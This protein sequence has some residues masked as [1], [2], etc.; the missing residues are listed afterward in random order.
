M[1]LSRAVDCRGLNDLERRQPG[2]AQ[3]LKLADMGEAAGLADIARIR[4][5]GRSATVI[6][7]LTGQIEPLAIEASPRAF[8]FAGP[9]VVMAPEIGQTPR[10]EPH[11]RGQGVLIMPFEI[12]RLHDVA[13]G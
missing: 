2:F 3:H 7:D 9:V 4:S 8:V 13:A 10:I 11:W 5:G 12:A 6:L 1:N